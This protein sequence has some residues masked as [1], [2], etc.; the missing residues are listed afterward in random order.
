M[1]LICLFKDLFGLKLNNL[2]LSANVSMCEI[3]SEN[4]WKQLIIC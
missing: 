3:V 2:S 4:L 1:L